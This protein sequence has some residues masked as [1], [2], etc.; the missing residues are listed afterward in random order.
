M[1]KYKQKILSDYKNKSEL[2]QEFCQAIGQVMESM[3]KK[4]AYKYHLS[5]RVKEF[6]SLD[7]KIERKEKNGKVYK[8]LKDIEDIA[9]V[10][11]VFYH[12]SDRDELMK[13]LK[14]EFGSTVKLEETSKVSGYRSMHAIVSF[15]N[16]RLSLSEYERFKGLKCEVQLTL[17]LDHAWAEVEHD[18]LYKEDAEISLLS[19]KDYLYL[20]KKMETV[21][22]EYIKKGSEEL[23][24]IAT[25]IKKIKAAAK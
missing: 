23:E 3:L 9:G 5:Y 1:N 18:I 17:I 11:V 25:E 15:S 24:S 2:Y 21:M 12:R 10:R 8:S 16:N 7:E 22:S 19:R 6:A 4:G 14:K 20:K 13:M